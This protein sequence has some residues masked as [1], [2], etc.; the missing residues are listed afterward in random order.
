[1]RDVM[2]SFPDRVTPAKD[3]CG[4]LLSRLPIATTKAIKARFQVA[5][6]SEH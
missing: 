4:P 2:Q 5:Q 1:V 6:G 3:P